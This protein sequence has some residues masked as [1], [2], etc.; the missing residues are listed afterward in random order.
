MEKNDIAEFI[1]KTIQDVKSGMPKGCAL[2]G[3]FDFDISVTTEKKT[4]GKIDVHLAGIGRSSGSQ[5]T[6]RIRFQIIDEKSR[7]KNTNYVRSFMSE[8]ASDLARLD[9]KYRLR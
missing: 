2:G 5:Q 9:K 1:S 3:V 6:H 8:M 7:E 4:G